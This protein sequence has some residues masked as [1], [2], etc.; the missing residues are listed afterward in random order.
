MTYVRR[1]PLNRRPLTALEPHYRQAQNSLR[2]RLLTIPL[3]TVKV[4][5]RFNTGIPPVFLHY[6]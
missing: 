1:R 4:V 6:S 2:L 3:C 5:I